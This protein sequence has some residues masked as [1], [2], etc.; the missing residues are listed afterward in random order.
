MFAAGKNFLWNL[1]YESWTEL[2]LSKEDKVRIAETL[3]PAK[4]PFVV[5]TTLGLLDFPIPDRIK[6][7]F[8]I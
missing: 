7:I 6:F 5:I 4:C 2:S 1:S 3:L 8:P